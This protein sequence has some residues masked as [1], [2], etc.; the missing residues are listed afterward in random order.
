MPTTTKV[1]RVAKPAST[2][3]KPAA[4][5]ASTTTKS[6]NTTVKKPAAKSKTTKA[7]PAKAAPVKAETETPKVA[8][9]F[10]VFGFV[11]G[12]DSSII[13]H[14]LIEGVTEGGREG[15]AELVRE[16]IEAANGLQTRNGT[17]KYIPSLV[18]GVL[19]KLRKQGFTEESSF[20]VVPPAELAQAV[21]TVKRK[22]ARANNTASKTK[23]TK[24]RATSK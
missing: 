12:S 19:L 16:R 17:E 13:A 5:K 1:K 10:D 11:V 9:D 22:A 8:R 3:S 18:S 23:V 14:T 21:A 2:K 24:R 20:K 7:A 15:M 6:K 4:S